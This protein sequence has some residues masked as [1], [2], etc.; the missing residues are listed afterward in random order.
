M[1]SA[2][3]ANAFV[4]TGA[5]D[6]ASGGDVPAPSHENSPGSGLP[7]LKAVLCNANASAAGDAPGLADAGRNPASGATEAV[8]PG[9]AT[10]SS[11]GAA[12]GVV[13]GRGASVTPGG[14]VVLALPA[15]HPAAN[16]PS[17]TL[18]TSLRRPAS[19]RPATWR[20]RA[21]VRPA[22]QFPR[23]AAGAALAPTLH[24]RACPESSRRAPLRA[25]LSR[26]AA[27]TPRLKSPAR[28]TWPDGTTVHQDLQQI[29]PPARTG[30]PGTPQASCRSP[31]IL[32]CIILII[33]E[34]GQGQHHTG[35]LNGHAPAQSD[36]GC[37]RSFTA[38]TRW[39]HPARWHRSD[40]YDRPPIGNLLA[41]AS[42][43]GVRRLRDVA[44]V[45][46]HGD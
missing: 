28:D 27:T 42:L 1:S 32:H 29:R 33:R 46:A 18:R 2:T 9:F 17:K 20:S 10:G 3:S 31:H 38:S 6:H 40:V 21:S 24:A 12:D 35:R 19:V 36:H 45:A 7:V 8:T 44:V 22:R 16:S 30:W 5:P 15:W 4:P 39:L 43:Q 26:P 34:P 14:S 23:A 37:K 13:A 41:A 25:W 11:D